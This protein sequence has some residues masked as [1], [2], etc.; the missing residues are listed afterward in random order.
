MFKS[1]MTLVAV[2][3][4]IIENGVID[5]HDDGEDEDES[6]DEDANRS[7]LPKFTFLCT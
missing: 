4:M 6:D 3:I 2:V 1:I 7:L 5:A